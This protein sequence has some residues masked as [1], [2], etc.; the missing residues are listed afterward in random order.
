MHR[1][2]EQQLASVLARL[3]ASIDLT[4]YP[5]ERMADIS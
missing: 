5:A 2:K 4:L 3:S 1:G